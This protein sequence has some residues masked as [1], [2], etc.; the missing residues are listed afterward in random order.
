MLHQPGRS[1]AVGYSIIHQAD[2]T[3]PGNSL[4][5]GEVRTET[6]G[7]SMRGVERRSEAS[8]RVGA[9]SIPGVQGQSGYSVRALVRQPTAFSN[10]I[11]HDIAIPVSAGFHKG[12][13]LFLHDA[14]KTGQGS[15]SALMPE[16]RRTIKESR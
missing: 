7:L 1:P 10:D 9:E 3:H 6:W 11:F 14:D 4:W 12:S 13:V 2:E 8:P 15:G 5:H 16:G